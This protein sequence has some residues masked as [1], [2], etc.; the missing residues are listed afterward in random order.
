MS[1]NTKNNGCKNRTYRLFFTNGHSTLYRTSPS[2][3]LKVFT[4]D[5]NI[6]NFQEEL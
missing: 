2:K 1:K 6:E 4:K 3:I 5:K